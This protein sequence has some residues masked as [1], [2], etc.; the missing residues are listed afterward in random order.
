MQEGAAMTNDKRDLLD[1]LKAE[2][3]FLEKGGYRITARVP[4]RPQFLFQDSPTCQNFDP[5]HPQIPCS[6]CV[7]MQLLPEKLRDK[8]IACRYIPLN[9]RG[10]TIDSFYRSGTQEEL[11]ATFSR[12][13]KATIA[14]LEHEKA[15][16]LR[17]SEHPEMHVHTT[18]AA[19]R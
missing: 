8:K 11:E 1:V 9:E 19:S 14:R 16:N 5:A 3:Q 17:A 18:L 12:W 4:W 15:E 6:D 7:L 10:E 13:L 2:L